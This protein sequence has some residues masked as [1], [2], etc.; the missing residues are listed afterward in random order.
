[1]SKKTYKNSEQSNDQI[2][3]STLFNEQ[4]PNFEQ[5]LEILGIFD[6]GTL[7]CKTD[8]LSSTTQKHLKSS[9]GRT[10]REGVLSIT[11]FL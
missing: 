9:D 2:Y 5:F 7:L 6:Q 8:K 3:F 4:N 10:N 1:M 11:L